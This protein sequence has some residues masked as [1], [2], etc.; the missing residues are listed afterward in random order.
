ME[1]KAILGVPWTVV[2]FGANTVI[3]TVTTLLLARLLSPNDFCVIAVALMVVSRRAIADDRRGVRQWSGDRR[4]GGEH[5]E[6]CS[7][8]LSGVVALGDEA[9]VPPPNR[10][11]HP[12][13]VSARGTGVSAIRTKS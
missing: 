8:D 1:E 5:I 3:T 13:H 9:R 7:L 2:S 4:D 11:D 6:P 12:P 10:L